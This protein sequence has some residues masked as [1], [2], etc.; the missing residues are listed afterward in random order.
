MHIKK[1][2]FDGDDWVPGK[3]MSFKGF[4]ALMIIIYHM[5]GFVSMDPMSDLNTREFPREI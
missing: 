1:N 3:I 5:T 4:V 2:K